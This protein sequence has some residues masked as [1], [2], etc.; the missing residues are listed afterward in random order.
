M[1]CENKDVME[2]IMHMKIKFKN[3]G[4]LLECFHN[5]GHSETHLPG[6]KPKDYNAL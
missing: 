5:R 1:T 3:A 2:G 4:T 6:K